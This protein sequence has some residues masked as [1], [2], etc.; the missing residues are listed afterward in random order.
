[1]RLEDYIY[2]QREDAVIDTMIQAVQDLLEDYG[3]IPERV[4]ERLKETEEK[5]LIRTWLKIA[6]KANGIEEF[7]AALTL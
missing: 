1:M 4:K 3:D 2:Y 7:E 6:A 5:T